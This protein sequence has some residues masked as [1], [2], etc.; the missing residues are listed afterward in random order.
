MRFLGLVE[1]PCCQRHFILLEGLPQILIFSDLLF[2]R[3]YNLLCL[4][5]GDRMRRGVLNV[6][7]NLCFDQISCLLKQCICG[8]RLFNL[9]MSI[10]FFQFGIRIGFYCQL[11][12]DH[13]F[14]LD[15]FCFNDISSLENRIT[16]LRLRQNII[17]FIMGSQHDG[18]HIP[19]TGTLPIG[20]AQAATYHLLSQNFR[21]GRPKRDDSIEIVDIPALF[22]HIDMDHDLHRIFRI[23]H[24][25]KQTSVRFGLCTLLFRVDDDRFVAICAT[26]EFV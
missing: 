21:S 3:F 15:L 9:S 1:H 6:L 23:F 25:Q 24:I 11:G 8:I 5:R 10:R 4:H 2:D 20:Q 26:T 12:I 22:E 13:F 14:G 19:V 18:V 17:E 16:L 7:L